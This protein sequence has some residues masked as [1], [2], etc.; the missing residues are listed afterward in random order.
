MGVAGAD[1]TSVSAALKELHDRLLAERPEGVS[2]NEAACPLCLMGASNN[3]G[4]PTSQPEGGLMTTFTKEQVDAAIAEAVTKATAPLQEKIATLETASEES[5]VG[6]AVAEAVEPLQA[7]I[8]TIQ[9]ELEAAVQAQKVAEDAKAETDKFWAEAIE[10]AEAE[11]V[12]AA[13]KDERL[14]KVREVANFPE[15]FITKNADRYAAMSDDEFNARVEEWAEQARSLAEKGG[16][17]VPTATALQTERKPNDNQGSALGEL[18]SLRA[19]L[20]DPRTL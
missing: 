17:P 1:N 15:E 20:T 5:K 18:R 9:A 19:S 3:G 16:T 6:S 11:K 8:A 10:K 4:N 13:R 12:A 2:H 14:A 7:Q